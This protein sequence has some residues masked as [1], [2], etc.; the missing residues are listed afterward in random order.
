MKRII[1]LK[2]AVVEITNQA[3]SDDLQGIKK[4]VK[5]WHNRLSV[6]SIPRT[7]ITKLGRELFLDLDAWEEWLDGRSNESGPRPKGRPRASHNE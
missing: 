3:S 2:K 4:A 5:S 7:V 1:P 6:G